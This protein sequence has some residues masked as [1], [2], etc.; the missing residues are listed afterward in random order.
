METEIFTYQSHEDFAWEQAQN[1]ATQNLAPEDFITVAQERNS[2]RVQSPVPF[3]AKLDVPSPTREETQM[4]RPAPPTNE[5]ITPSSQ[6]TASSS[7]V[8][9]RLGRYF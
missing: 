8:F 5:Q 1:L 2:R 3:A 7:G 6:E 9:K 4:Q